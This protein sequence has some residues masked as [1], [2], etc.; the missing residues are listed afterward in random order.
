MLLNRRGGERLAFDI[1]GNVQRTDSGELQLIVLAPGEELRGRLHVS[2]ARVLVADR[3]REE[4][5]EVL[6]GLCPGV[7]NDARTGI[8][9][10]EAGRSGEGTNS[11]VMGASSIAEDEASVPTL[12]NPSGY[13]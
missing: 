10:G 9:P 1:G 11:P 5:E 12:E 8:I 7:G 4:F 13:R 6:A 3:G 2:R